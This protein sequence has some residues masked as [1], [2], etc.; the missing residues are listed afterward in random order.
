MCL[1]HRIEVTKATNGVS[2]DM[3]YTSEPDLAVRRR[4]TPSQRTIAEEAV[5]GVCDVYDSVDG[6]L[7]R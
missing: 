5:R 6:T 1:S 4:G 7:A 3:L 2:L